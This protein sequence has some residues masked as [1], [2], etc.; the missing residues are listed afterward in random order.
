M[1]DQAKHR[2]RELKGLVAVTAARG[3]LDVKAL[4]ARVVALVR[5]H[6]YVAGATTLVALAGAWAVYEAYFAGPA[7]RK[8]REQEQR[9]ARVH[10]DSPFALGFKNCPE[11]VEAIELAVE[12]EIPQWL[13]GKLFRSG[14][15]TL[16]VD[17][18]LGFTYLVN[19]WFDGLT[20]MHGFEIKE[21][22]VLYANQKAAREL[23]NYIAR[24]GGDFITFGP[25]PCKSTFDK[26]S[27]IFSMYLPADPQTGGDAINIGVTIK[28][29]QGQ[30]YNQTD[31]N[32]LM[33]FDP[34]TLKTSGKRATF[35]QFDKRLKGPFSSAHGQYDATR[36]EYINYVCDIGVGATYTIFAI[37]DEAEARV[38]CTFKAPNISYMH[39]FALTENYFVLQA[40]PL[41]ISAPKLLW[42]KAVLEAMSW[43][44]EDNARFYVVDRNTGEL[45]HA[46]ETPAAFCFH[47]INAWEEDDGNKIVMDL[48]LYDDSSLINDLLIDRILSASPK[49]ERG[50]L[51]RFTLKNVLRPTQPRKVKKQV[52]YA[53]T[54]ELPRINV[55][56]HMK[57]YTYV[58]GMSMSETDTSFLERIIKFNVRTGEKLVWMAEGLYPAEPIFIA[59]PGATDE[60]DGVLLSIV[61]SG[62][63]AKSFLLVLDAKDL[64]ELARAQLPHHIP[65]GFHGNFFGTEEDTNDTNHQ[66]ASEVA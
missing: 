64:S 11:T 37:P 25:D 41:Y 32:M 6:P 55:N 39:S 18:E 28:R 58:Y 40:W 49:Y 5:A 51:V 29:I 14:P 24:H 54:V 19:H 36:K 61:L 48:T 20:M 43:H 1:N 60:D 30:L 26:L 27:S 38:L 44:G 2:G 57:P 31:A 42:H 3:A 23:E 4:W 62:A 33:P 12:G 63:T 59:A 46:Y 10:A 47:N 66:E 53:N 15:G 8:R 35:E 52:V 50:A 21:G 16:E 13:A 22:R 17:T 45:V 34:Q 65:F 7:R 9:R 56:W